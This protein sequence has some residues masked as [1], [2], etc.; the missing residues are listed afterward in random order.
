MPAR[1]LE[2]GMRVAFGVF[3]FLMSTSLTACSLDRTSATDRPVRSQTL[4]IGSPEDVD[5]LNPVLSTQQVATDLFQLIYSGLIAYN[6][7]AE[8]IPDVALAIPTR[9]NGGISADGRT[10][11]YHLRHGVL[12]SDGVEVTSADVA[13][14][15]GA[16]MNPRNN[17][18]YRY[19]YDDVESLA[20]PDKYT[21]KVRLKQPLAPFV[22]AFM[23][24]GSVGSIVP[25]HVLE[26]VSDLNTSDF[27]AHP[28]GSGPF[29]VDTWKPGDML[30]L[31]ANARYWRGQPHLREIAFQVVPNDATLFTMVRSGDIDL[32]IDAP[33][34]QY[35]QLRSIPGYTVRATATWAREQIVFNTERAPLDDLRVRQAIA[36]AI[37]WKRIET[38][39]YHDLGE[40]T[41]A[42]QPPDSWA[43]D[44]SVAPYS[45]N[46]A[47]SR[48]LLA[49]AGWE[50][51]RDG[52]VT[53]NGDPLTLTISSTSGSRQRQEVETIV[54][55]ELRN[56][57]LSLQIR[58]V[59][60]NILFASYGAG[61]ILAK[62]GFDIALFAWNAKFPDPD[63][64]QTLL[65]GALP[66][67]G[68]NFSRWRDT[69]VDNLLLA[70][71]RSYDRATRA[72]MYHL[73]QRRL[74]DFVPQHTVEWLPTIDVVSAKMRGFKQA[75]VVSSFWNAYEWT[76]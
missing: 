50:P 37:D 34:E 75:R 24:N 70:A 59:P 10:I 43:Y 39:V 71:A 57:G 64:S 21:V 17:V 40:S 52:M 65:S 55:A 62:G 53:K 49:Q 29:V 5:N 26:G 22:A 47:E 2:T 46:D 45:L 7:R 58:N 51:G 16:I 3:L 56:I 8:P 14:T 44:A 11:I 76:F 30:R 41:M 4:R 73:V 67:A 23:R 31:Q 27:N 32:Y 48:K 9:K 12:F 19:P 60:A 42:D 66:P 1:D 18:P 33:E 72:K 36:H 35:S 61:G 54:Q 20:T 25:K 63:D 68:Q 69:V 13:F 38:D 15:W 74:H 28:I 6:D